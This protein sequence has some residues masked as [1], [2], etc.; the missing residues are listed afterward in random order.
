MSQTPSRE[1]R[2]AAVED[3]G[4]GAGARPEPP[5]SSGAPRGRA[6]ADVPTAP[7]VD[8]APTE[9]LPAIP[10]PRTP[11]GGPAGPASTGPGPA[12][13]APA[14]ARLPEPFRSAPGQVEPPRTGLRLPDLPP[15]VRPVLP[16]VLGAATALVLALG[17]V[18]GVNGASS[19]PA[20]APP[21]PPAPGPATP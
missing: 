16:A 9:A 2:H 21:A 10:R 11:A 14:V 5:A 4:T 6:P 15:T 12:G 8:D 17:V 3:P 1:P 7:A 20:P 18:A 19:D 13:P